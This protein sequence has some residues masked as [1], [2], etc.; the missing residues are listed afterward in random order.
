MAYSQEELNALRNQL[1]DLSRKA[2]P[3]WSDTDDQIF[4]AFWNENKDNPDAILNF[5]IAGKQE[6]PVSQQKSG[7]AS[8]FAVENGV[9]TYNGKPTSELTEEERRRLFG[10]VGGDILNDP[11]FR[12]TVQVGQGDAGFVEEQRVDPDLE[13]RLFRN[14]QWYR[15][16]GALRS[17]G[18]EGEVADVGQIVWDEE[19]GWITPM[20]NVREYE[21]TV[22]TPGMLLLAGGMLGAIGMAG[23][24]SG[25]GIGGA[26]A[27]GAATTSGFPAGAGIAGPSLET[28][29]IATGALEGAATTG[30]TTGAAT[31]AATGATTAGTGALGFPVGAGPGVGGPLL[32]TA[33]MGSGTGSSLLGSAGQWF[34]SLS[35]MA[36]RAI[37]SGLSTGASA[38]MAS[39]RQQEAQDF[40]RQQQ[41][42]QYDVRRQEEERA[43]AERAARGTPSQFTFNVS[44]RAPG[45]G[46]VGSNMGG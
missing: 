28:A 32:E 37:T 34:S 44:P 8:P 31:G 4:N 43:A 3:D 9:V 35:P 20:S 24:F 10:S 2:S 15:Q 18:G 42:R 13:Q 12:R 23:G 11:Q 40:A 14:G 39:R 46:L 29:G 17:V 19:L 41:E 33:A 22:F 16:V 27:E 21:D 7:G 26:A 38:I 30:A 6:E 45:K 5:P 36:Q 1:L 25:L